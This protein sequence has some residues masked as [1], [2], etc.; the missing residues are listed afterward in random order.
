M[1]LLIV[2]LLGVFGGA[3][4][5]HFLDVLGSVGEPGGMPGTLQ[6]Q[7]RHQMRFWMILKTVFGHSGDPLGGRGSTRNP[8]DGLQM[9]PQRLILDAL[10]AQRWLGQPEQDF[11]SKK[12]H[13]PGAGDIQNVAET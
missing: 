5:G 10:V 11:G 3:F 1:F 4:F 13:F 9:P 2:W 12:A 6:R 7:A 8:Q